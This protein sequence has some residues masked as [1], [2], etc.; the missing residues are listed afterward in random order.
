MLL[1]MCLGGDQHPQT[2]CYC[3]HN[4]EQNIFTWNLTTKKQTHEVQSPEA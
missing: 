1:Q 3:K 4:F 2:W